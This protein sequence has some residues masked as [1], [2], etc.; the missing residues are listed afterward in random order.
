MRVPKYQMIK[1]D[2]KKQLNSGKL[3]NGDKFY[4]EADLMEIYQ[5]SSITVIRALNDL[6]TEGYLVRRQGKGTFVS[7]AQR[8]FSVHFSN[9]AA[10]IGK[11]IR[12]LAITRGNEE[13]ILK[14]LALTEE[15]HYYCVEHLISDQGRPYAYSQAYLPEQFI[16][17]NYPELTYYESI[18]DRLK[19][20]FNL[21]LDDETFLAVHE[22]KL[23]TPDDVAK[24]LEM[25]AS[26]PTLLETKTISS[27]ET[28]QVFEYIESYT[29]W[30]YYKIQ[31]TSG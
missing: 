30:D 12:V 7:K 19:Q 16:N 31:L 23:P 24:L 27:N 21:H 15:Q 25:E 20:D 29:K 5:V 28:N 6:V 14:K 3:E 18:H 8:G 22:V 1:N 2:L 26:E 9:Q 4:T 10:G 11:D 17:P 13:R